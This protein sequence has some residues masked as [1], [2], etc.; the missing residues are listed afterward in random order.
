MT[1]FE[2]FGKIVTGTGDIINWAGTKL[3]E[4]GEYLGR[5]ETPEELKAKAKDAASSVKGTV[6][7]TANTVSKKASDLGKQVANK[8]DKKQAEVTPNKDIVVDFPEAPVDD[9]K[10]KSVVVEVL[11]P[12]K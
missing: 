1:L 6:S 9:A 3:Q 4:G 11:T 12:N 10:Q 7:D 5:P 2:G 8:V